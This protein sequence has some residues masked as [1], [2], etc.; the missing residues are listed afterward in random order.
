[1]HLFVHVRFTFTS[2]IGGTRQQVDGSI[3]R[4]EEEGGAPIDEGAFSISY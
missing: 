1:M 3:W 4:H 2:S